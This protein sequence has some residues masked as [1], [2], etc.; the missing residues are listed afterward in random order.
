MQE[1]YPERLGAA[2]TCNEPMLFAAMWRMVKGWIDPVTTA[3][4]QFAG[5]NATE[6]L[7]KYIDADVLATSIG[8][9]HQI[10]P[11]PDRSLEVETSEFLKSSTPPTISDPSALRGCTDETIIDGGRPCVF[12]GQTTL[13]AG[14][15][16]SV[17]V[18]LEASTKS[19]SWNFE[20]L[21]KRE[22][23]FGYKVVM[24]AQKAPPAMGISSMFG[25]YNVGAAAAVAA[26]GN[27]L[28]MSQEPAPIYFA[29]GK[30]TGSIDI[31][32]NWSGGILNLIFDNSAAKLF[33]ATMDYEVTVE[34]NE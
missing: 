12:A 23:A 28:L 21:K 2:I 29:Q 20:E 11:C 16:Y 5:K 18:H 27:S 32:Q 6:V 22:I 1:Q 31:Q 33:R 4:F 19:V 17:Q 24:P 34:V 26:K 14:A 10:Y 8:G 25:G 15:I 3:K 30:A 9:N 13:V 7:L